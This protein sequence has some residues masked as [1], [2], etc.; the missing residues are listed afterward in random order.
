M[1]L[2]EVE[3]LRAHRRQAARPLI[4]CGPKLELHEAYY[5]FGIL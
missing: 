4:G 2:P 5:I 1:I 3:C